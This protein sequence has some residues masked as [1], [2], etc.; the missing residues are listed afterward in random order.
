MSSKT[1]R[2]TQIVGSKQQQ[3]QQVNS[4]WIKALNIK[5]DS[6]KLPEDIKGASFTE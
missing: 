1:G 3:Q 5:P 6:L 2:D 4:K